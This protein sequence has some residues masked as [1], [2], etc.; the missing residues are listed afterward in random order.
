MHLANN[1]FYCPDTSTKWSCIYVSVP[2]YTNTY[3]HL[4]T[5][6]HRIGEHDGGLAYDWFTAPVK[7]RQAAADRPKPSISGHF[8]RQ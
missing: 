1:A 3:A 4:Q 7:W 5:F 2:I 8:G 6:D